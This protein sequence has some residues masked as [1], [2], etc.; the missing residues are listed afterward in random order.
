RWPRLSPVTAIV[1]RAASADLAGSIVNSG[2]PLAPGTRP[3]R[4]PVIS[5][6]WSGPPACAVAGAVAGPPAG[7][8]AGPPVNPPAGAATLVGAAM[9]SGAATAAGAAAAAPVATRLVTPAAH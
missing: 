8:V 1:C 5:S 4:M 9:W 6:T 7:A 3:N 2:R